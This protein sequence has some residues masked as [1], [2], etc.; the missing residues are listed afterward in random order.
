MRLYNCKTPLSNVELGGGTDSSQVGPENGIPKPRNEDSRNHRLRVREAP[1]PR[2]EAH[3][4]RYRD[5]DY[6]ERAPFSA[7]A[8][9]AVRRV[10]DAAH[11]D[12]TA[13]DDAYDNDEDHVEERVAKQECHRGQA[14]DRG[15]PLERLEGEGGE[16]ET[17]KVAPS[18]AQKNPGR[19]RVVDEKSGPG[20][21]Q[22]PGEDQI[23]RRAIEEAD[24]HEPGG[25][26]RDDSAH[27]SVHRVEE[28]D[29][30]Q[31]GRHAEDG[32][33]ERE[34]IRADPFDLGPPENEAEGGRELSRELSERRHRAPVVEEPHSKR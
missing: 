32:R 26:D 24:R 28:V 4:K 21:H 9:D 29:R 27:D 33:D 22:T 25:G 11:V 16:R 10:I 8:P 13:S 34:R 7:P 30:V 31:E 23:D 1:N 15:R 17:E 19:G 18:V 5:D 14:R 6:A 2:P 12:R 20:T 3:V